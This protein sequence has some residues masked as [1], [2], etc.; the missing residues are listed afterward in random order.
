VLKLKT[1]KKEKFSEIAFK[2]E[3]NEVT[4]KKDKKL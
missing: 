1:F 4:L 3:V 2:Q